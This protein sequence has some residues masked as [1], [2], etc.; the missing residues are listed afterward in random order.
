MPNH[1]LLAILTGLMLFGSA[2]LA[3]AAYDLAQLQQIE[4][5]VSS[6]NLVG[7]RLFLSANPEVMRGDDELAQEL[8]RVYFCAIGSG[9]DC[10]NAP[11]PAVTPVPAVP[12]TVVAVTKAQITE[13]ALP[14]TYDPRAPKPARGGGT[15]SPKDNSAHY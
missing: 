9:L 5:L 6:R 7:L 11:R 14:P 15:G 4:K 1:R 13:P 3:R 10:F 2:G 8:T 12:A